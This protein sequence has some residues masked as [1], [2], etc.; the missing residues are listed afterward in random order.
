MIMIIDI[1]KRVRI[2]SQYP[3][4]CGRNFY[5]TLRALDCLQLTDIAGYLYW[6]GIDKAWFERFGAFAADDGNGNMARG[7]F[8]H[9]TAGEIFLEGYYDVLPPYQVRTATGVAVYE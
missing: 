2:I 4:T 9:R 7:T 3:I 6:L 1:D 8:A 5:E